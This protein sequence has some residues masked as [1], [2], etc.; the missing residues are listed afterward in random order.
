MK[1]TSLS[2]AVLMAAAGLIFTACGNKAE[3]GSTEGTDAKT[4]E[5]S[6]PEFSKVCTSDTKFGVLVENYKYG[7]KEPVAFKS[8]DF[9]VKQSSWKM[10][11]DSTAEL[12]ICNYTEEEIIAGRTNEQ[13]E[14]KIYL[15]AKKGKKIEAGNYP[16]LEY[17]SDLYSKV[18]LITAQGIVWFNWSS[19]MPEPG[20]V[21]ISYAD[22]NDVCGTFALAV[23]KPDNATIGTVRLN[24]SFKVEKK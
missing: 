16:Y 24:G 3:A 7:T 14:V 10:L 4:E 17:K 12:S 6:G 1:K 19:G 18:N 8:P 22:K 15:Y 21:T 5:S 11:T 9:N 23:E 2:V 20:T 13:M